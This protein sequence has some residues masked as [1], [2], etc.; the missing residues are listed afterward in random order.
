MTPANDNA[1]E[2]SVEYQ[3][4]DDPDA[5]SELERIQLCYQAG[6]L[7]YKMQPLQAPDYDDFRRWNEERQSDA[8]TKRVREELN[9]LFDNMWVDEEGRRCGKTAK[10]LNIDVEEMCRRV[11]CRGLI[12]TAFQKSIGSIVVPLVGILFAD[13]PV[14]FRPIYKGTNRITGDHEC[15]YVPATNSSAKLVGLD[16]HPDAV[17][18]SGLDFAHITEAC[19]VKGL[20]NVVMSEIYPQFSR[21][22]WAWIALESST[23]KVPDHDF[24]VVFR[25]DARK[26]GCYTKHII[27]ENTELSPE[28]IQKEIARSGGMNHKTCRREL[29]CEQTRDDDV[30]VVPEFDAPDELH[31]Y[32]R[33]V[34]DPAQWPMPQHALA[35]TCIDP[36]LTDPAGVVHMYFDWMRQCIVVTEAW[37]KSNLSIGAVARR[38]RESESRLWG[39]EHPLPPEKFT[40]HTAASAP[41]SIRDALEQGID[42]K[43]WEPPP[44]SLTYWDEAAW[45]LLPNPY[46]R[47]SDVDAYFINE[48]KVEQRISVRKAHKGPGSAVADLEYLRDLFDAKPTKIVILKNGRTEDL[49]MQLRSGMWNTDAEGHRTDWLRTAT[50]GHL[51]CLAALK[52]GARD[53]NFRRNPTPP[54][55][56]DVNAADIVHPP[57]LIERARGD[58]DNGVYG[59]RGQRTS[60]GT[61][62]SNFR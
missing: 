22:P 27:T 40:E 9:A 1:P 18:G 4:L 50:L 46:A 10:W 59:G 36:G 57:A 54:V 60:F 24:N 13:A 39:T 23:A 56:R 14:G 31:P 7:G 19:F 58:N 44:A 15:L 6:K 48:L 61:G 28:E 21:R 55:Y 34:V 52:Y 25:E 5:L 45:S 35:W 3:P 51:D 38:L 62:R 29:F 47:I 11:N 17:R 12:A 32:T 2:P 49:I 30:T 53:V 33:H 42:G 20:A 16:L 26:R 43:V 41:M 37:A 8:Y